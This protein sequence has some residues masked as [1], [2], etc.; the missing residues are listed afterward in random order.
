V[1]KKDA[2]DN[3][4]FLCI[5]ISGFVNSMSGSLLRWA[6]FHVNRIQ[7]A[8]HKLMLLK[9]QLKCKGAGA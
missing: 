4:D 3:T 8:L 6:K 9:L 7:E 1:I 5:S 2:L